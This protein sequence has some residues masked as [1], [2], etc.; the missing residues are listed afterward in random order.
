MRT[1]LTTA[2]LALAPLFSLF[3][4]AAATRS[5]KRGLI[6][7][8]PREYPE[9]SAIWDRFEF[10]PMM[11]GLDGDPGNPVF[12]DKVK[13]MIEDSVNITHVLSFNEPD[14][15][16][17]T[18]GSDISPKD[19]ARAWVANFE[20]LSRDLGVKVGLP[21]CTGAPSGLAW[22]TSFLKE[23]SALVSE[24]QDKKRNCTYDFLPIHWYGNFE[25]LASHVGERLALF[26]DTPIWVTEYAL[27]HEELEPSQEFFNQT[28]DWFDKEEFIERYAYFGAFRSTNS[29][30]GP[31]PVFLNRD[32]D[33]TD[34]GSWYLGGNATGVNPQSGDNGA[35]MMR[36]SMSLV[37]GA[38]IWATMFLL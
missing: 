7:I 14:G 24:G 12:Y 16:M 23:C 38:G 1:S 8:N 11:W 31:N 10:V 36:A 26:P 27:A 28:I 32:G 17:S 33:L 3:H 18:G 15:T 21:G 25:G 20:P 35:G 4:T 29:N 19:A 2:L 5:P 9:D 13:A 22:L 6:F 30:V 34:I 37:L